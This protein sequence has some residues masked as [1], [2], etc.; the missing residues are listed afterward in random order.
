MRA[1]KCCAALGKDTDAVRHFEAV[2]AIEPENS[3][4][5]RAVGCYAALLLSTHAML[6][7]TQLPNPL[8]PSQMSDFKAIE[9]FC[10]HAETAL[11]AKQYNNAISFLVLTGQRSAAAAGPPSNNPQSPSPPPPPRTKL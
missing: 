9:T 6:L 3:A 1:A 10:T 7:L 5:K 11:Q 2:L 8:L 4:A